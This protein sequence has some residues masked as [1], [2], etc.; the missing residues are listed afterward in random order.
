MT[1]SVI[2]SVVIPDSNQRHYKRYQVEAIWKLIRYFR[3]VYRLL[4]LSK[5]STVLY[6]SL[7]DSYRI[8][9]DES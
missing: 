2:G 1:F 6:G 4:K 3:H 9:H 8:I 5:V 7:G